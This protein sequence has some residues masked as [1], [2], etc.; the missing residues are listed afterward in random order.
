MSWTTLT[1]SDFLSKTQRGSGYDV[2]GRGMDT[3]YDVTGRGTDTGYDVMEKGLDTGNV[4]IT[5]SFFNPTKR[6]FNVSVRFGHY[7]LSDFENC[8][9]TKFKICSFK[10]YKKSLSGFQIL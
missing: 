5:Y 6:F 10:N 1:T 4:G 7:F 9:L 2:T 8:P 3:G